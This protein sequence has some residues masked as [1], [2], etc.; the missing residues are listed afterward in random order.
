MNLQKKKRSFIDATESGALS[1]LGFL[2][3]IYFIVIAGFN[4][5]QGFLLNLPQKNST[6]IVN[7][8]DITKI[9]LKP[10]GELI[11]DGK[12]INYDDAKVII[13]ERV[14]RSPNMTLLLKIYPDALYQDVVNI[15]NLSKELEIDNFS[16][17]MVKEEK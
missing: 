14:R 11:F 8:E 5:N 13:K 1:D 12:T 16:F 17:S 15:I 2:L 10:H 9:Y 6:K 3:I 7:V 4:I